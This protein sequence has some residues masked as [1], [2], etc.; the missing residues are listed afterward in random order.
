MPESELEEYANRAGTTANYIKVHL[1]APNGPRKR[2]GVR[3]MAG[4]FSA[5]KGAVSWS[6]IQNWFYPNPTDALPP[7]LTKEDAA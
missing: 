5:A 6:D 7:E 3:L 2:P 1:I 4:L